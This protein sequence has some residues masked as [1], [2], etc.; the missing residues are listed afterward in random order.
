[1]ANDLEIQQCVISK[2]KD[3]S[4]IKDIIDISIVRNELVQN[5]N[6]ITETVGGSH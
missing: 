2:T 5:E 6:R 3:N 1:M 4:T